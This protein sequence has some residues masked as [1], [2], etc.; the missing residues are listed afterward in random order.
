MRPY[1][2]DIQKKISSRGLWKT[3]KIDRCE[4]GED[5]PLAAAACSQHRGAGEARGRARGPWKIENVCFCKGIPRSDG[6][7]IQAF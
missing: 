3:G 4:T 7:M 1:L 6:P 2:C 5:M